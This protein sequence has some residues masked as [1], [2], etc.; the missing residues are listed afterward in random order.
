MMSPKERVKLNIYK[1]LLEE[2]K[3]KN[4]R[5]SWISVSLFMLGIVTTST[6]NVL[7]DGLG[8]TRPERTYVSSHERELMTIDQIFEQKLVN[9]KQ[10]DLSPD[11][12]FAIDIQG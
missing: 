2:E 11:E 9:E 3:R 8:F 5:M 10:V 6:Y 1:Q 7:K 4:K 12:F